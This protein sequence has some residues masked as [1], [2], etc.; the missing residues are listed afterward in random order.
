MS[1]V[2]QTV[3]ELVHWVKQ[4][5]FAINLPTERL[6]FLLAIAV[7]SGDRFD[8]ELGEGEL[9]DAF[10]IVSDLF[11]QTK[12][13]LA[14][15]ANNAINELVRQR[16]ISRFTSEITDG[17]SIYRLSPLALGITDYYVRQREYSTLK[18]SIQ[19]AMVADEIN[20]A[21]KSA[22]EDGDIKHWRQNVYAVLKFSVAEIFDRIDL[23][24]RTMDEH[25]QQ[26]KLDIAE[27][28]NKDW[29]AAISSC[30][31]LLD[32]TSETLRELQDTLQAAG[33]QL[34]TQLLII[35]ES[36]QG[37]EELDFVDGMIF[38]L[39]MKLDRIISWGQQAIDLWIGYDRH[40]HKFIRTAIDMDKNRAFSQRLRQSVTDYFDN[41]WLLT[42]ADADRL[43][44]MRDEALILRDDEVTGIVPG[45]LEFEELDLV[46]DEL[47][48]RVAE[49]LS[50]HKATGAPIN[51]SALLKDYLTK[52][53]L[54]YHFDLARIVIDQAVRMG[55]SEDDFNAIQP[56]WE[57]INDYGAKVQANVINKY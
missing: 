45:E 53:P 17:A 49:M 15:R 16:L 3:P 55:Y 48:D 26:V 35:Q 37:R 47:A 54:A 27:L 23:N 18:L 33:D 28:L 2:T 11:G 46:N 22:Q 19:L 41:P 56:D 24:Q 10:R 14:F 52:H 29:R 7:L 31:T 57:A 39:Q 40:V 9:I 42:Y 36:T 8:E 6:A 25:Q 38:I 5:E 50:A 1:E 21:A 34:Q 44:D 30:E 13:T 4:N 32:E 51:L 20:K 43:V 12:E